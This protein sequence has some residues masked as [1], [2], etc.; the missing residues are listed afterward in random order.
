[1]T[2]GDLSN[3][4]LIEL[5]QSGAQFATGGATAPGPNWAGVQNP[6]YSQGLVEFA[7]NEGYK[8]MMGDIEMLELALI[9]YTFLSTTTTYIY[10]FPPAPTASLVF[11][12]VSHIAR[13]YYHPFGLLYTREFRPGTE[14]VSWAKFQR[15]TGQGYLLPYSFG[16]QPTWATVDPLRQNIYFYPGSARSGDIV[17]VQYSPIPSPYIGGVAPTG[18]P[19]LVNSTDTPIT[20]YDTHMAIFYYAM[21][22]LWIRAREADQAKVSRAMY[23]A[24]IKLIKDKYTKITHA[25]T[26]TVEP[27]MDSLAIGGPR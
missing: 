7:V 13:I 9:D 27:F 5:Q 20:P 8:K 23:D 24:E 3:L 18:C 26:I 15:V 10:P 17:T 14:L 2:L 6:Q 21:H 22:L 25:D 16:T 19:I 11:P 12:E 4:V 1:M